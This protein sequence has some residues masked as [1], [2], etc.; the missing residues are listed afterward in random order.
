[1]EVMHPEN[2]CN[3]LFSRQWNSKLGI[4]TSKES[5]NEGPEKNII[6]MF[7]HILRNFNEKATTFL[8]KNIIYK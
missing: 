1:M 4:V 5:N 7:F 2:A 3:A 8:K 6:I